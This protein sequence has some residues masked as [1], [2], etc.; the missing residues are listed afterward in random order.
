MT[1]VCPISF[2]LNPETLFTLRLL[3]ERNNKSLSQTIK[4][5]IAHYSSTIKFSSYKERSKKDPKT[6]SQPTKTTPKKTPK[7]KCSATS[8]TSS[9]NNQ[10]SLRKT[11]P[12][13]FGFNL[14]TPTVST[15]SPAGD[16]NTTLA[17]SA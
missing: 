15:P 5:A 7:K 14:G 6:K 2:R 16:I 4:D 11:K 9:R 10:S 3:A 12:K 13:G 8:P 17:A 1:K